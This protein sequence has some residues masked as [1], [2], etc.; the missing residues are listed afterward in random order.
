MPH[1]FQLWSGHLTAQK[2]RYSCT[3]WDFKWIRTQLECHSIGMECQ[4]IAD[5]SAA[6]HLLFRTV[7]LLSQL[8]IHRLE[9]RYNHIS[10]AASYSS[11]CQTLL[12]YVNWS[13]TNAQHL[14][15]GSLSTLRRP[16]M[17]AMWH[18]LELPWFGSWNA[19]SRTLWCPGKWFRP[20]HSSMSPVLGFCFLCFLGRCPNLASWVCWYLG[21]CQELLCQTYQAISV[22]QS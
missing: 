18:K 17:H 20:W 9:S 5:S 7:S 16:A 4:D 8:Q 10:Q 3:Y 19:W 11:Y 21:R 15:Y 1:D 6:I 22:S 2:F 14:T 13:Q 12:L